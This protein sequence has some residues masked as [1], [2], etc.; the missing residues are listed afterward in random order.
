MKLPIMGR[1]RSFAAV[2]V[3]PSVMGIGPAFAIPV[4]LKKAGIT[5]EDVD[6]FEINEV[7]ILLIVVL[8]LFA[9]RLSP[10]KL[11]TAWRSSALILHDRCS[12]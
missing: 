8:T 7:Q 2:G 3:E 6:V 9:V 5:I 1:F 10:V 11:S 4:A 12:E